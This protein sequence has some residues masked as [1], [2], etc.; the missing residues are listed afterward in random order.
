MHLRSNCF[1]IHFCADTY[2]LSLS[3]SL[4]LLKAPHIQRLEQ[5]M[6]GNF[7]RETNGK[8]FAL[9]E[10]HCEK[11]KMKLKRKKKEE[12]EEDSDDDDDDNSELAFERKNHREPPDVI[13]PCGK[14]WNAGDLA[15][16]CRDCQKSSSSSV[17]AP[18]F[19]E[20]DHVGH[21]FTIY[22]SEAGGVCDCGDYESWASSGCCFRHGGTSRANDEKE[23]MNDVED[24]GFFE[25]DEEEE[26]EFWDSASEDRLLRVRLKQKNVS[27]RTR[28]RRM[29]GE[30]LFHRYWLKD[31]RRKF[32]T[33]I[34]LD[35][36]V[37]RL[38]LA[39]KNTRRLKIRYAELTQ[40]VRF[41]EDANT[42]FG[43]FEPIN[44]DD[45]MVYTAKEKQYV[46]KKVAPFVVS[47]D[48]FPFCFYRNEKRARY[49]EHEQRSRREAFR[50]ASNR[51]M[52]LNERVPRAVLEQLEEISVASSVLTGEHADESGSNADD[53]ELHVQLDPMKYD[54]LSPTARMQKLESMRDEYRVI[55]ER[56]RIE[57]TAALVIARW[58]MHQF[59]DSDIVE[60]KECLAMAFISSP[61][62]KYA[63]KDSRMDNPD[64]QNDPN[65]DWK[66][67][68][69]LSNV[70]L[71]NG[72]ENDHGHLSSVQKELEDSIAVQQMWRDIAHVH[73][74]IEDSMEEWLEDVSIRTRG[75]SSNTHED[76]EKGEKF[77]DWGRKKWKNCWYEPRYDK[78]ERNQ[79]KANCMNSLFVIM[80]EMSETPDGEVYSDIVSIF[81]KLIVSSAF[82]QMYYA[83]GKTES[84]GQ[85]RFKCHVEFESL[86]E[87]RTHFF[88]IYMHMYF[89]LS[90]VGFMFPWSSLKP[91][92]SSE[93]FR[94]R[95]KYDR[96]RADL[97]DRIGVQLFASSSLLSA[98]N[99]SIRY[100]TEE[101]YLSANEKETWFDLF[102]THQRL[103]WSVKA[104]VDE[105]LRNLLKNPTW[106]VDHPCTESWEENVRSSY[107]GLANR[108]IS[109]LRN[110]AMNSTSNAINFVSG[111]HLLFE[112]FEEMFM[113]GS[114][115]VEPVIRAHESHVG[116]ESEEW[117]NI[118][119]LEFNLVQM[120]KDILHKAL[121]DPA[122]DEQGGIDISQEGDD[123][124][125]RRNACAEHLRLRHI[126]YFL[127]ARV[128]SSVQRVYTSDI[129]G[130]RNEIDARNP[131]APHLRCLDITIQALYDYYSRNLEMRSNVKESIARMCEEFFRNDSSLD[132]RKAFGKDLLPT[133]MFNHTTAFNLGECSDKWAVFQENGINC[134]EIIALRVS[135]ILHW[136]FQV[137]AR[138]WILNGD[139]MRL[140]SHT[141]SVGNFK[142]VSRFCD[143]SLL[144]KVLTFSP[145]KSILFAVEIFLLRAADV[146]YRFSG[147]S[148]HPYRSIHEL[149]E[150]LIT[151][152]KG[153]GPPARIQEHF[154]FA[155]AGLLLEPEKAVMCLRDAM[156]ILAYF[157]TRQ[158]QS[159]FCFDTECERVEN[160]IIHTV[161]LKESA[162]TGPTYSNIQSRLSVSQ[163]TEKSLDE[164]LERLCIVKKPSTSAL[165]QQSETS[166]FSMKVTYELK[167]EIWAKFNAFHIDYTDEERDA[168][169]ANAIRRNS[170][171][172]PIS[173]SSAPSHE[174]DHSAFKFRFSVSPVIAYICSLSIR[175]AAFNEDQNPIYDDV[176]LAAFV[177]LDDAMRNISSQL[178]TSSRLDIL[179]KF[180]E[181]IDAHIEAR[182][183]SS[184]GD[185]DVAMSELKIYAKACDEYFNED[186][187]T[188]KDGFNSSTLEL[189]SRIEDTEPAFISDCELHPSSKFGTGVPE[190]PEQLRASE[191]EVVQNW[192]QLW[193]DY[194]SAKRECIEFIKY[195]TYDKS[196]RKPRC[197]EIGT[198]SLDR[199]IRELGET[200][201]IWKEKK[202]SARTLRDDRSSFCEAVYLL[203]T[204]QERK[205]SNEDILRRTAIKVAKSMRK[206]NHLCLIDVQ[207]Y[208][209]IAHRTG[210]FAGDG[211]NPSSSSSSN[212]RE[213]DGN[214]DD[215][216]LKQE[217]KAR[218]KARQ[219]QM[220]K[221]MRERQRKASQALGISDDDENSAEKNDSTN[222]SSSP[223]SSL[224]QHDVCAGCGNAINKD[225]FD[226]CL[227]AKFMLVNHA[228]VLKRNEFDRRI[229]QS[230]ED[231]DRGIL[232]ER[233][234]RFDDE[235]SD[236]ANEIMHD[237]CLSVETGGLIAQSCGHKMHLKCLRKHK[238]ATGAQEPGLGADLENHQSMVFVKGAN[239]FENTTPRTED[240]SLGNPEE[241]TLW[242]NGEERRRQVFI[243]REGGLVHGQFHCPTCRRV[244][245]CA[246][247][248]LEDQSK[249]S[250]GAVDVSDMCNMERV[251]L[252]REL[253]ESIFCNLASADY[254]GWLHLSSFIKVYG[255][256]FV[257]RHPHIQNAAR[258][259][260]VPM[261]NELT[262]LQYHINSMGMKVEAYR[263]IALEDITRFTTRRDYNALWKSAIAGICF[264]ELA[265]RPTLRDEITVA[266]D[267]ANNLSIDA[268]WL[269][270]ISLA[271]LAFAF[272]NF[273]SRASSMILH[274]NAFNLN[275]HEP[276]SVSE[277]GI[278]RFISPSKRRLYLVLRR[279][280]LLEASGFSWLFSNFEKNNME[281]ELNN[282]DWKVIERNTGY[283]IDRN[284]CTY[285]RVL[286]SGV[287]EVMHFP[288]SRQTM[289]Y[290]QDTRSSSVNTYLAGESVWM[291]KTMNR[292]EGESYEAKDKNFE[293]YGMDPF[294]E[295]VHTMLWCF[296][297]IR[298][299]FSIND[300]EDEEIWDV[301][302]KLPQR[303]SWP[304]KKFLEE[305]DIEEFLT[306]LRMDILGV[307]V[308]GVFVI[309]EKKE[310]VFIL[311]ENLDYLSSLHFR[312]GAVIDAAKVSTKSGEAGGESSV[313][314]KMPRKYD[315][316][317]INNILSWAL[318]DVFG[319]K[320]HP[321]ITV[322]SYKE[323][324]EICEK[325]KRYDSNTLK[326]PSLVKPPKRHEDLLLASKEPC[327]CC[328]RV[329]EV[330]AMCL[331]CGDIFC[332]ADELCNPELCTQREGDPN[333][334]ER[335]L[336]PFDVIA[337]NNN[338]NLRGKGEWGLYKHARLCGQRTCVFVLPHLTKTL[339]LD[340]QYA[341]MCPSLYV[342]AHG[343]EDENGQRGVRL[344]L[345]EQ[346]FNVINNAWRTGALVFQG[347]SS[348]VLKGQRSMA[349]QW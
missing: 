70:L 259:D 17:C 126:L 59:A 189:F 200:I 3:L 68:M 111:D 241:N 261:E 233:M 273:S 188:L 258:D 222:I 277:E 92:V 125:E 281:E 109:D 314:I 221:E 267:E 268:T 272:M 36:A 10:E 248:I 347:G 313:R 310:N 282:T 148:T 263:G 297:S 149:M 201:D 95:R 15:Y 82:L 195:L 283:S 81:L 257:F 202:R 96:I 194:A 52:L 131:H 197:S 292:E 6:A 34:A 61:S 102:R 94:G 165:E 294:L 228:D 76:E 173:E 133:G 162:R 289:R 208:N 105:D 316:G 25:E 93:T 33:A 146:G 224:V 150:R 198:D 315:V 318:E 107:V 253:V 122:S 134:S 1:L 329:P 90:H 22:R 42:S 336:T 74:E 14:E 41:R 156:N 39:V 176:A 266:G 62:E 213:R 167:E 13:N 190:I 55:V 153:K 63:M 306:R 66:T 112:F 48:K 46:V 120:Y 16:R 40:V 243:R 312:M 170:D 293:K 23:K 145:R 219:E 100:G 215:E 60:W 335:N 216:N 307:Y 43:E 278:F 337:R 37:R 20:S 271:K 236:M 199:L 168:A 286:E 136:S 56:I 51:A 309:D 324:E 328:Q 45:G 50:S 73:A 184:E 338:R 211:S 326:A 144:G 340:D 322:A 270:S 321:E 181:A 89:D 179:K 58:L 123:I 57:R 54:G 161:A 116:R 300:E 88:K 108:P 274:D 27:E 304:P 196:L 210:A 158:T 345:V 140:Y 265:M 117:F 235:F 31:E 291:L 5:F 101:N 32:R 295:F 342:D 290:R 186:L 53:A 269:A 332:A 166:A 85:N 288:S 67:R 220:M 132:D 137:N 78:I 249:S 29:S 230:G 91:S 177:I 47:N 214:D 285:A 72:C 138:A 325:K 79:L 204:R 175:L 302:D 226:A 339:I 30:E 18:C 121:L 246:I 207:T 49:E 4:S 114:N 280:D 69:R 7:S 64:L 217:R 252:E 128:V 231:Y 298:Q 250:R 139:Q 244:S 254:G 130:S 247:P 239:V 223:S 275:L 245:D 320:T 160:S 124:G 142:F 11:M 172:T 346:R 154:P 343:E 319:S 174:F 8:Y 21:D 192:S 205:N 256:Y 2:S 349:K 9:V 209:D 143:I 348:P 171:W 303:E 28:Q 237:T 333:T 118:V 262:G 284:I 206:N 115:L 334:N 311:R 255:H 305:D 251:L 127:K 155:C 24:D 178:T 19:K 344:F 147:P 169:K 193:H 341:R 203:T 84:Y 86:G 183:L 104:F 65:M 218:L 38:V 98:V 141:Y 159:L 35:I 12:K 164:Y 301:F 77:Q 323:I 191:I 187:E 110:F 299:G 229:K 232:K 240:F 157:A 227:I 276:N 331:L 279:L 317:G 99:D 225:E 182:G 327:K 212:E 129:E 163:A 151:E 287:M 260:D 119:A 185:E 238:I 71:K 44:R 103:L 75:R 87:F 242:A 180:D 83:H 330:A 308:K 113:F 106:H 234:S 296:E 152:G 97:L 135:D 264:C 26:D 80:H